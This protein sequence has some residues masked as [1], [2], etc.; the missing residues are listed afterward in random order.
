MTSHTL[1]SF[2]ARRARRCSLLASWALLFGAGCGGQYTRP[3]D[4]GIGGAAQYPLPGAAGS[5]S[6][7]GAPSAGAQASGGAIDTDISAGASNTAGALDTGEGGSSSAGAAGAV[8]ST[9]PSCSPLAMTCGPAGNES[10]CAAN[11]VPGGSYVRHA[12][13]KDYPATVSD[14]VLDRFEIT[15]GRFRNFLAMYSPQMI[16]PGA[17]KNPH[18]PQDPGWDP[19]WNASLPADV[20]AL[21][22]ALACGDDFQTWDHAAGDATTENLPLTCMSWFEAEAFCIWDQGRLPTD[23]EWTYAAAGGGEQRLYPWGKAQPDC[24]FAN[25]YGAAN[26][27]DFC[28]LPGVGAANPVGSE[29]PKGDGKWGHADLGGNISEWMQ[30]YAHVF[31]V[32]CQDCAALGPSNASGNRL[33][34]GG[35]FGEN[36][37]V[38]QARFRVSG[39]GKAQLFGARCARPPSAMK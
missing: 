15:V 12:N 25:Y 23:A 36:A 31:P 26:G 30:D 27:T 24:T 38:M 10:C 37:E 29:S 19:A 6:G 7:G 28:V 22:A 20:A 5:S 8:Q 18:N 14:F 32:E 1:D 3:G 9:Q 35:S 21:E 16:A 33:V 39:P 4:S 2:S 17:G 13:G 34:K 11:A